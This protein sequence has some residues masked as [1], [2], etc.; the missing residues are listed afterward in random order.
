M[1]LLLLYSNV[2]YL[3]LH[4]YVTKFAIFVTSAISLCRYPVY[5]NKLHTTTMHESINTLKHCSH[6]SF[7]LDVLW[8]A[9]DAVI[10]SMT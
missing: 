10:R 1:I 2:C 8:S 3:C 5:S 4:I 9:I 7:A 6:L